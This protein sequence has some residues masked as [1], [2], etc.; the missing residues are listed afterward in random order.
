MAGKRRALVPVVTSAI[1]ITLKMDGTKRNCAKVCGHLAARIAEA[2]RE[3]I[4]YPG[5][6]EV[7]YEWT[8]HTIK[9]LDAP[10]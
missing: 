9:N 3:D 4:H 5:E 7:D 10:T 1:M 8:V 6:G 2:M